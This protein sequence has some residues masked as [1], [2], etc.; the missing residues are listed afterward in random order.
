[1]G[2]SEGHLKV[3]PIGWD[4]NGCEVVARRLGF[5]SMSPA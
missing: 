4:F 1:M 2:N 3:T 5:F